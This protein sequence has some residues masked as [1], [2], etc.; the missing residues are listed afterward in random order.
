MNIAEPIGNNDANIIW[1][2]HFWDHLIQDIS[3][4]YNNSEVTAQS[5]ATLEEILKI[6]IPKGFFLPVT[7]GTKKI[8]LIDGM[9]R[10][11]PAHFTINGSVFV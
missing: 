3:P 2:W 9:P 5:G 7:P 1:E 11:L 8:T 10:M 6:I 4:D